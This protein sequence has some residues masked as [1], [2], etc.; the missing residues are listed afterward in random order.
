MRDGIIIGGILAATLAVSLLFWVGLMPRLSVPG[1]SNRIRAGSVAG[2]GLILLGLPIGG[3]VVLA[4]RSVTAICALLIGW[5][6]VVRAS[7]WF[8]ARKCLAPGLKAR[9]SV[10]PGGAA[11]PPS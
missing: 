6:M 10:P 2:F 4:E 9:Q 5:G 1:V 11:R 7:A 3:L 8:A